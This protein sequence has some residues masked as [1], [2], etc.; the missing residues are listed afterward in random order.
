MPEARRRVREGL[1]LIVGLSRRRTE[2]IQ[3]RLVDVGLLARIGPAP[4]GSAP[5]EPERATGRL[6]R[7]VAIA[8]AIPL[9]AF[10]LFRAREPAT[11]PADTPASTAGRPAVAE[12][13]HRLA[14]RAGFE[15][16]RHGHLW[17]VLLAQILEAGPTPDGD[18][19]LRL[20]DETGTVIWTGSLPSRA[21]RDREV[22][23]GD[24]TLTQRSLN[25]RL[26][27]AEVFLQGGERLTLEGNW[28]GRSSAPAELEVPPPTRF[29]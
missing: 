25:G 15:R 10:A 27:L 3:S 14:L 12:T 11:P 23:T 28:Q 16:S 20:R 8:V 18:L 29:R 5:L 19:V 9:L 24:G 21:A 1:P 4:R 7:Q 2:E 22:P 6:A 26:S 17:L 13:A